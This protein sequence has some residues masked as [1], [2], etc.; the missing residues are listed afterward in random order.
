MSIL[1][2]GS[3]DEDLAQE[4]GYSKYDLMHRKQPHTNKMKSGF[5]FAKKSNVKLTLAVARPFSTVF[6]GSILILRSLKKKAS[7]F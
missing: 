1:L 5:Y 7:T 2:E 3:L 6:N 4:L